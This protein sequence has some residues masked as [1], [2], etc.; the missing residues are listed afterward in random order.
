MSSFSRRF[1]VLRVR[2]FRIFF[3]GNCTS[4]LGDNMTA[5]ALAF[6]VLE[7]TRSATAVGVVMAAR[8][9]ALTLVVLFGGVLADRLPRSVVMRSADMACVVSQG[10][11]AFLLLTRTA[12]VWEL[13]VLQVVLGASSA[14]FAPAVSGLMR[15]I[16]QDTDQRASANALRSLAQSAVSIAGPLLA[17]VLV[18]GVGAGW[19]I[20]ADAASYAVSAACLWQIATAA[21]SPDPGGQ[22]GMVRELLEGWRA[23]RSRNWVWSVIAVTSYSN[24]VYAALMVIGPVIAL[25]SWHDP[26]RWG[27]FLAALGVGSVVGA[28][29]ALH[30]RPLHPM[31]S[32]VP[33]LMLLAL[34]AL[35]M[36]RTSEVA[37][38]VGA[39]FL[40]GV[41]MMVFNPLWENSLQNH[42]DPQVLSRVSA[43][44]WFGSFLTQPVGMVIAAPL[45]G[46]LSAGGTLLIFGILQIVLI[47]LP[48]LS[49]ELRE[50]GDGSADSESRLAGNPVPISD[51]Q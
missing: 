48:L 47:P 49:R 21:P 3:I 29:A 20:A 11:T 15:D 19:A 10:L 39:G 36:S 12:A 7:L 28:A 35:V 30:V 50:L 27:Y 4:L 18:T 22:Q 34:P 9:L 33:I 26:H 2:K 1:Q 16:V 42:I 41:A 23:F 32:A 14:I 13:A 38:V 37:A 43:Y 6:A 25:N 24:M 8:V 31:R 44:E 17:V 46:L 51:P 40:A 45:L 5:P